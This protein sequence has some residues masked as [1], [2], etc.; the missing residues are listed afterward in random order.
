MNICPLRARREFAVRR[1]G[2]SNCSYFSK[3]PHLR[4]WS[5]ERIEPVPQAFSRR[6]QQLLSTRMLIEWN[7]RGNQVHD[8]VASIG[9]TA[10]CFAASL[11]VC[12]FDMLDTSYI[13][14][15]E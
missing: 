12:Y 14:P 1:V 8:M 10:V 4:R 5:E 2:G 6:P 15:N 9:S 3:T 11:R 7:Q 13:I